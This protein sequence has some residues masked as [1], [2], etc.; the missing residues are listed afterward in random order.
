MARTWIV[1]LFAAVLSGCGT[2]VGFSG[3]LPDAL[4]TD[5]GDDEVTDEEEQ[6]TCDGNPFT[7]RIDGVRIA[8]PDEGFDLDRH[9][10]LDSSDPIGCGKADGIGGVDNMLAQ[11]EP[12]LNDLGVAIGPA[13]VEAVRNGQVRIDITVAGLDDIV[14]DDCVLVDVAANGEVVTTGEEGSVVGGVLSISM[15][16]LPL[17]G[18]IDPGTGPIY[19]DITARAVEL[20]LPLAGDPITVHSG[21]LGAGLPW[22]EVNNEADI[23]AIVQANI[24]PSYF[25]LVEAIIMGM[26]DLQPSSGAD[27][28]SCDALSAALVVDARTL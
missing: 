27:T 1:F 19:A 14:D 11:L 17:S 18:T 5:E 23:R 22:D 26:L 7:L 2:T 21:M 24:E 6:T 28:A 3:P 12:T 25:P 4:D 13:L 9:E 15:Y 16:E 20:E 8:S 10:T